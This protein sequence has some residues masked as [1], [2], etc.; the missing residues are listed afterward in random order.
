VLQSGAD[1]HATNKAGECVLMASSALCAGVIHDFV[2]RPRSLEFIAGR[3]LPLLCPDID[4]AS[5][6]TANLPS[7][8]TESSA[9]SASAP[10]I[11]LGAED[12][13]AVA[14]APS[15]AD[16]MIVEETSSAV[17]PSDGQSDELPPPPQAQ[18]QEQL[19]PLST[20]FPE[21]VTTGHMAPAATKEAD[22]TDDDQ[23]ALETAPTTT[24][25][26]TRTT[27]T[28]HD[29]RRQQRQAVARVTALLE[30]VL[31]ALQ[32][33][34][35]APAETD[36]IVARADKEEDRETDRRVRWERNESLVRLKSQ[37]T[38]WLKAS[39]ARIP[40]ITRNLSFSTLSE[41]EM[42]L[43]L[44]QWKALQLLKQ[45]QQQQ[46]Q[47]QQGAEE[48]GDGRK[49]KSALLPSPNDLRQDDD[50]HRI[51]YLHQELMKMVLV[52]LVVRHRRMKRKTT[53]HNLPR[54]ALMMTST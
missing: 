17:P 6:I 2:T 20:S 43:Y 4:V 3:L 51:A 54:K 10:H 21:I 39:K 53:S 24:K 48:R 13:S 42:G 41:S 49:R 19:Q 15:P 50:A 7:G 23:M 9:T 16:Q 8:D 32:L 33:Y 35:G 46:K 12:A 38:G 26:T 5:L 47:K 34:H 40:R 37:L 18:Q 52:L 29:V 1:A 11:T 27:R 36:P 45:Q 25:P 44:R 22:D 31:E 30:R 28:A 14:L